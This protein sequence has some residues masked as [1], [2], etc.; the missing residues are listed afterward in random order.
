MLWGLYMASIFPLW[1]KFFAQSEHSR[2]KSLLR[3]TLLV[4]F[5][6]SVIIVFCGYAFTPLIMRI[7]G[8]SKF[9]SSMQPFKILI[10]ATPFFFLNSIFY[11]IILSFGKTKYLILP[12]AISLVLNILMN[13]Y[14]IPKYGYMGASY[15]T[16]ITEICTSLFYAVIFI[17]NLKEEAS[18]YIKI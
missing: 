8:G 15:T 2:Y 9:F 4:L 1:S 14:A 13:L 18:L 5:G 16:V 6:L 12:L 10:L 7:L 11:Y 3:D 17:H